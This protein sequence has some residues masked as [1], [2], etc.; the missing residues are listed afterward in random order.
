[1]PQTRDLCISSFKPCLKQPCKTLLVK[2]VVVSSIN[3]SQHHQNECNLLCTL[4]LP[5]KHS[6]HKFPNLNKILLWHMILLLPMPPKQ[7]Q[8]LWIKADG[9]VLSWILSLFTFTSAKHTLLVVSPCLIY[10]QQWL[11]CKFSITTQLLSYTE[12]HSFV[13]LFFFKMSERQRH[14]QVLTEQIGVESANTWVLKSPARNHC[15]QSQK[16][17][18]TRDSN[19]HLYSSLVKSFNKDPTFNRPLGSC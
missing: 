10:A 1:M 15:S 7:M 2:H 11:Y 6:S 19:S 5:T 13:Y 17:T 8:L 4:Q 18:F 9:C 14:A 16:C 3:L 12:A